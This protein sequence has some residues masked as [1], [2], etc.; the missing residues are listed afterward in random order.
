MLSRAGLRCW[1]SPRR[2]KYIVW[3]T[4]HCATFSK[5][6]LCWPDQVDLPVDSL[7]SVNGAQTHARLI[8]P[9]WSHQHLE[10]W[11]EERLSKLSENIKQES[12]GL[13]QLSNSNAIKQLAPHDPKSPPC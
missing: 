10:T 5:P 2:L 13:S 7:L 9:M 6:G 12:R 8:S 11:Q 1:E 4:G 3:Q